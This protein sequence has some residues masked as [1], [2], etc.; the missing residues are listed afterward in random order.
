MTLLYS[1][2]L[3]FRSSRYIEGLYTNWEGEEQEEEL[4]QVGGFCSSLLGSVCGFCYLLCIAHI[5]QGQTLIG[6]PEQ[7]LVVFPDLF[8]IRFRENKPFESLL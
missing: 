7:T 1:C 4:E 3:L 6:I 2:S 5:S 8:D